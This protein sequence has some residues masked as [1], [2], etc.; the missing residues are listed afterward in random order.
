VLIPRPETETLV[1]LALEWL[2]RDAT[3]RTPPTVAGLPHGDGPEVLDLG[4]GSGA[5][6]LALAHERG[7]AHV[8]ATDVSAAALAVA[9]G[10]A[11]RLALPN[12]EFVQADWYAA[13]SPRR[14][15]LITSNPPYVALG[16]PHLAAGDLR[17]EPP[18]ALASGV[19]GLAALRTIVGG[20]R[21]HLLPG[22]AL[23]VEH[24][25]DQSDA[26]QGLLRAAGFEGIVVRRDLAGIPRVAAGRLPRAA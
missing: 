14:F 3:A 1:E 16:D 26:V 4:T 7:A 15:A 23:I 22:G 19:D 20:A 10:N 25:F 2:P 6:A 9:C 5:I 11:Q 21:N 12:V 8:V 18:A 13:L 24:G 17:F